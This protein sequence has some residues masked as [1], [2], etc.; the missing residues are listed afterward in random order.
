MGTMTIT[1]N[2]PPVDQGSGDRWNLTDEQMRKERAAREEVLRTLVPFLQSLEHRPL[3]RSGNVSGFELLGSGKWT[4][5][6]HY[7]L[8]IE[9][10][11]LDQRLVDQLAEV[12]PTGS[13]V[14]VVGEFESLVNSGGSRA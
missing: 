8:L 13:S 1:I 10:D 14:S 5:F 9:I 2:T 3:R 4:S 11:F 12:L 7:L 6:H